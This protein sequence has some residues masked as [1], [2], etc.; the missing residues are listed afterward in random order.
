MLAVRLSHPPALYLSWR[1]LKSTASTLVGITPVGTRFDS[2]THSLTHSL[3]TLAAAASNR[4]P[5]RNRNRPCPATAAR[6][7]SSH[8]AASVPPTRAPAAPVHCARPPSQLACGGRGAR[9]GKLSTHPSTS[10]SLTDVEQHHRYMASSS[11]APNL[12]QFVPLPLLTC[13]VCRVRFVWFKTKANTIIYKCP[14][15]HVV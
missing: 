14:N 8:A 1:S 11:A 12:S 3:P 15:N 9:R 13:T 6:E 5:R 7:L 2:T 10:S 4:E